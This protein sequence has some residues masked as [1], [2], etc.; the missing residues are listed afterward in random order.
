MQ[1]LQLFILLRIHQP[2]FYDKQSQSFQSK[3]DTSS[4]QSDLEPKKVDEYRY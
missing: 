1:I 4:P 2:H 3:Q